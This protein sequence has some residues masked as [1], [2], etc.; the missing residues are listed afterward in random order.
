MIERLERETDPSNIN[1]C[2]PP[3]NQLDYAFN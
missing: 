2:N 1:L 3:L